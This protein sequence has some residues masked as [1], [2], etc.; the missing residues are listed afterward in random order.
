MAGSTRAARASCAPPT[1][2][3]WVALV[4]LATP[5]RADDCPPAHVCLSERALR[6]CDADQST[7]TATLVELRATMRRLELAQGD[8]AM[9]SRALDT[10]SRVVVDLRRQLAEERRRWPWWGWL[11]IGS[12]LTLVVVVVGLLSF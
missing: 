5:A 11:G 6:Q 12:G 7:L 1:L 8:A 9:L 4:L 2:L 3:A 10:E